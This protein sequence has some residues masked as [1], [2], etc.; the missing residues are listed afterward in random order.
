ME[1][2]SLAGTG[3]VWRLV[4]PRPLHLPQAGPGLLV[5]TLMPDSGLCTS[6]CCQYLQATSGQH[7]CIACQFHCSPPPPPHSLGGRGKQDLLPSLVACSLPCGPH[8]HHHQPCTFSHMSDIRFTNSSCGPEHCDKGRIPP[9]QLY[10]SK[11]SSV[12]T[13]V[14]SEL[15]AKCS[16]TFAP[17]LIKDPD[18]MQQHTKRNTTMQNNVSV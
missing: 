2:E 16:A 7:V 18:T 14:V 17:Y 3:L 1:A 10:E 11:T 13:N 4:Q 6:L 5:F 8:H 12:F 9:S 15:V